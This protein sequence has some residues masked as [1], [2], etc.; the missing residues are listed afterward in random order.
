VVPIH[1]SFNS[2]HTSAVRSHLRPNRNLGALRQARVGNSTMA[3]GPPGSSGEE[4][5]GAWKEIDETGPRFG[6]R[7]YRETV[8]TQPGAIGP[9]RRNR[10]NLVP[11]LPHFAIPLVLVHD[12]RGRPIHSAQSRST[13]CPQA[14][15]SK[16]R[17]L[18]PNA[19]ATKL[20]SS[21]M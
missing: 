20:D 19:E 11:S 6:G 21:R 7:Q 8:I 16:D 1:V 4:D 13:Y 18:S 9:L 15:C 2:N 5:P 17:T 3:A 14:T 10:V 12:Y